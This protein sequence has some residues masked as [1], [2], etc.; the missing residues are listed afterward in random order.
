MHDLQRC[1]VDAEAEGVK[2][3]VGQLKAEPQFERLELPRVLRES[4][5]RVVRNKLAVVQVDLLQFLARLRD[6]DNAVVRD[7][8]ARLEA[9]VSDVLQVRGDVEQGLVAQM[10]AA[11]HRQGHQLEDALGEELD[12]FVRDVEEVKK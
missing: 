8:H 9:Q 7:P 2:T 6:L 5:E 3:V 12:A 11:V 1:R 10:R 4:Q